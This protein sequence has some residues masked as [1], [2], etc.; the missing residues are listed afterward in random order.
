MR[1]AGIVNQ[2]VEKREPRMRE[3][4]KTMKESKNQDRSDGE[5]H[6]PPSNA[7][8]SAFRRHDKCGEPTE[9]STP[10]SLRPSWML[11]MLHPSDNRHIQTIRISLLDAYDALY[12]LEK[13]S[14]G[15]NRPIPRNDRSRGG[16]SVGS[17]EAMV[18]SLR[19][20]R[21]PCRGGLED[22][23]VKVT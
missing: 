15:S 18:A 3:K 13:E 12:E 6:G 7:R 19:H 8:S 17:T 23:R 4:R 5:G 16:V 11:S 10:H 22:N 20:D 21:G 9:L 2:I 14:R 1:L